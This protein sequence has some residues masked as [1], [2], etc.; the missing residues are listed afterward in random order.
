MLVGGVFYIWHKY[1]VENALQAEYD[2][3]NEDYVNA[4]ENTES[5]LNF[6]WT[7]AD[8]AEE[9]AGTVWYKQLSVNF[10]GLNR[11]NSDVIAWIY[12]E[13]EDLSYP[14]LYSGDDYYLHRTIE[15]TRSVNGA[16]YM[17]GNNS[18][19]FSDDITIIYGHNMRN[20]SMFGK[21]KNFKEKKYYKKHP[22]F[23]IITED[24]MAYRYKIFAFFDIKGNEGKMIDV[25]FFD[26]EDPETYI[27]EMV[28][29][30]GATEG[31]TQMESVIVNS[32]HT[33]E[34]FL[35]VIKERNMLQTDIEV[36]DEDRLVELFTC[37]TDK[38]NRFTVY[39]VKVAE[40]NF[41]EVEEKNM[42]D[43]QL[44]DR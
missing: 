24:G 40:H 38:G 25:A 3:L 4:Q 6:H 28:P 7:D 39:G 23:Q 33:Y 37:S 27:T 41:N 22:Y 9:T 19:D 8:P 20:S 30:E 35:Q 43:L 14:I 15:K 18:P 21:L 26:S 1:A 34:N 32:E 36:T 11:I 44:L 5:G 17:Q 31:S 29:V 12:L 10:D 2:R 13:N 42:E 16:I